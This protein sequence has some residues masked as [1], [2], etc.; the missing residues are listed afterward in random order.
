[1]KYLIL[2]FF[3]ILFTISYAQT[4]PFEGSMTWTVAV[5]V[6]DV[7]ATDKYKKE[8]LKE[9]NSEIDETILELEQQLNDPEMQYLLLEN[10]NTNSN[11]QTANNKFT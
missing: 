10:P 9:D 7:N 11:N 1:M 8:T 4:L 5:D 6:L 2:I 3:S